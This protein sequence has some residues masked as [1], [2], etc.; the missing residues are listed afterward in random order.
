MYIQKEEQEENQFL[1]YQD[2]TFTLRILAQWEEYHSVEL[3]VAALGE[4]GVETLVDGHY[5]PAATVTQWFQPIN[6]LCVLPLFVQAPQSAIKKRPSLKRLP[7]R[8]SY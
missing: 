4:V 5:G 1:T 3:V 6:F 8:Q 2:L 7:L